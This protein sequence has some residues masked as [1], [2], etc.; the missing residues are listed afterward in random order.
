MNK[1]ALSVAINDILS[2]IRASGQ[3]EA[4]TNQHAAG[5]ERLCALASSRG[6]QYYSDEL[7]AE[8]LKIGENAGKTALQVYKRCVWRLRSYL[9]DGNPLPSYKRKQVSF[10]QIADGFKPALE[11]YDQQESA[12]G[13][14]ESSLHKNRRVVCYLLEFMTAIGHQTLS[15]IRPGDTTDAIE[16]MLDKHYT[17]SSLGTAI[18]G[19]RRFYRMFP[20]IEPF[21]MEIPD[22]L[23]RTH[24]IIEVYSEEECS[25]IK[26]FLQTGD[27]SIRDTA[28]CLLSFETGIRSVDIRNLRLSNI[29]WKHN[30]IQIIQ[31][32]TKRPLILPL[33]P[34]YGN[35]MAKYILNERPK[36]QLDYVF[37]SAFAPYRQLSNESSINQIIRNM[38]TKAGIDIKEKGAGTRI[39]RHNAASIMVRK[40][41]ALPVIAEALGHQSEDSTM[42]YITTDREKLSTLTLPLPKECD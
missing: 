20:E 40:G 7:E 36:S 24:H 22:R 42:I 27:I 3:N 41:V 30:S 4:Y 21:H 25:K 10:Y 15:D 17:P 29:D 31:S 16:A 35:A 1:V 34:S 2:A 11:K 18:S 19:L 12:S 13:L 38:L 5:F 14:S 33:R 8:F 23:L 26:S 32:K 37:L 6:E 39:F 28:I 9:E